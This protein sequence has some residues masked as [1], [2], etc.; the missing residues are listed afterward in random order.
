[1][2][3]SGN[4]LEAYWGGGIRVY[5]ST[6]QLKKTLHFPTAETNMLWALIRDNDGITWAGCQHGYIHLLDK[7]YELIKTL[8]PEEMENSTI[9]CMAKDSKGNFYFGLHNGKIVTWN[10]ILKK[11]RS[12]ATDRQPDNISL[13]S[14]VTIFTDNRDRCWAGTMNGISLFDQEKG[15]YTASF[16]PSVNMPTPCHGI[17]QVNDSVLVTGLE[18]GGLYFFNLHGNR[19]F[20]PTGVKAQAMSS[21]YAVKKDGSANIW[22]TTDFDICR[23]NPASGSIMLSSPEKG[24]LNSGFEGNYFISGTAGRWFTWTKTEMIGFS[25]DVLM[26][27][28]KII[29]PVSITGLTVFDRPVYIDSLLRASKPVELSYKNNFIAISFSNLLFSN[30]GRTRYFYRLSGVDKDWVD[31]G[32]GHMASYTSLVPGH[33]RFEVTTGSPSNIKDMAVIDLALTPPFWQTGWFRGLIVLLS[34]GLVLLIVYWYTRNIRRESD[35]KQQMVR[36]EMMALRAQMNPH[37][38]FNCINSI[39]ALIQSDD[40]YLATVYLNKFARLIRNILDSSKENTITLKRDLETLQLYVDLERFR[41]RNNFSVCIRTDDGL[42][43]QDFKVPPLIIQPYVENAILHGLRHR[44]GGEG[45]L[46]ID[47]SR[48]N[49]QLRYVIED[50]G[51]G[52]AASLSG[53][54]KYRSYGMEMS[55]DR[56]KLFNQQADI[57]VV[58]TDLVK[59]GKA[60]GTRVEVSLQIK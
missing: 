37:F 39:D 56:L 31:N 15:F 19:F 22:F 51:V 44:S 30:P 34:L 24:Y 17:D 20:R 43:Q 36:T 23:Y 49:D 11:F 53:N 27:P 1:M 38:I 58:I 5:N 52:R 59:D 45:K 42:L 48:Q 2:D 55:V 33:Y 14:V 26:T 7:N 8:H 57:P 25:P 21:V 54:K 60:V 18:N 29:S 16:K 28:D 32:S 9:R 13:S 4:I 10:A 3:S 12:F 47:I 40:K 41:N 46:T 50:N 6:L 35:M